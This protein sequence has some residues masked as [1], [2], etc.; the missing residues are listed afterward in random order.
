MSDFDYCF[1][2]AFL[3]DHQAEIV[4]KWCVHDSEDIWHVCTFD[5][6]NYYAEGY[7]KLDRENWTFTRL[8]ERPDMEQ[9]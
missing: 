1:A 7:W 9:A 3:G 8:S 2:A 5:S 6:N 4:H